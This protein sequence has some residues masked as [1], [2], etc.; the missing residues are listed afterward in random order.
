MSRLVVTQ[1]RDCG[2]T[3]A[4]IFSELR[5]QIGGCWEGSEFS[6]GGVLLRI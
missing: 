3:V 5:S 2:E 6:I 4:T 1:V